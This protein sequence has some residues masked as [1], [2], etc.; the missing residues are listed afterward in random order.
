VKSTGDFGRNRAARDG[1]TSY[2]RGCHNAV[3][4]EAKKRLYGS[5][6]EYH[7]RARYG[8]TQADV[9]AML[10][11]QA[12]LCPGCGG[13]DPG[14]VDHDHAT[15][16]VRGMLCFNC[17][18]ALG[19]VRDDMR[20]LTNLTNYLLEHKLASLAVPVDES[21]IEAGLELVLTAH[22]RTD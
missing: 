5:S 4:Q 16:R 22:G 12:G 20:V 15:G 2:C 11:A 14:H 7:L 8:L 1:L 6:R 18:Q 21:R 9:D 13:A 19:N 3:G 17:N 10:A